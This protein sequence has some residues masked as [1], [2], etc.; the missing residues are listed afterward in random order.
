[1]GLHQIPSCFSKTAYND[2]LLL[3]S[4]NTSIENYMYHFLIII[5]K[6]SLDLGIV[7]KVQICDY[8][9]LN[10]QDLLSCSSYLP[11]LGFFFFFLVSSHTL[12]S[13][14]L[15]QTENSAFLTS[16]CL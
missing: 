13:A 12:P 2:S 6:D 5:F 9:P 14:S 8:L 7:R 4:A 1:M 10:L 15:L 16:P 3:S 11:S